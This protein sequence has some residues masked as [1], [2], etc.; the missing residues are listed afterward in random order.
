MMF[1]LPSPLTSP[2]TDDAACVPD[3]DWDGAAALVGDW[4]PCGLPALPTDS[5]FGA[6]RVPELPLPNPLTFDTGADCPEGELPELLPEEVGPTICTSEPPE[7]EFP[8]LL[9]EDMP[10]P[11]A[12]PL[13]LLPEETPL[14]IELE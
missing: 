6:I 9:P 13:E 14:P 2:R 3:V 8:E 12:G 11:V 5:P 1:S 10:G 4:L 7:E